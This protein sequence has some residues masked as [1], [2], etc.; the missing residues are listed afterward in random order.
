MSPLLHEPAD[1]E[2]VRPAAG[3]WPTVSVIVPAYNAAAF[4]REAIESS[5]AQTVP[6]LEVIVV[7]D[8]STDDTGAVADAV[9]REHP[10]VQVIHQENGGPAVARNTAIAVAR[11]EFLTFLDADDAMSADRIE[12]QVGYLLAHPDTDVVIG[13]VERS[14]EAGVE[15]DA[16]FLKH[17]LIAEQFAEGIN[18]MAMTARA[19][20][21][22][23]LGTFDPSYRLSEDYQW[24]VRAHRQ[25]RTVALVPRVV[26]RR[27][28]HETNVSNAVDDVRNQMFRVLREH[29]RERQRDPNTRA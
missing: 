29:I 13:S 28:L 20:T 23:S 22:A 11:G 26:G 7:N 24:L 10:V 18:L 9:A 1:A 16:E 2:V 5:V 17:E 14:T 21:F 4:L 6:P 15:L 12:H 27:R 19:S 8:G 3:E 25:A